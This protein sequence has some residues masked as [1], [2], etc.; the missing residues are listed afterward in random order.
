MI[1]KS[2]YSERPILPE[3][4]KH[5]VTM[6]WCVWTQ[7]SVAEEVGVVTLLVVRAQGLLGE[8]TVEWRTQDG[9]A[10]SSGKTPPDYEVCNLADADIDLW[11][12][13]NICMVLGAR[14]NGNFCTFM[15][16]SALLADA[17]L[18]TKV[19]ASSELIWK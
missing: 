10:R 11:R 4:D 2:T 7:M 6:V 12:L 5:C 15:K 18:K 9:T 8:V 16:Y 14:L 17:N 19:K 13:H 1:K 3:A